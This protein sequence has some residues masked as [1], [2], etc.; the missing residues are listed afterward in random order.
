MEIPGFTIQ[1]RGYFG[2][3]G[4]EGESMTHFSK[5]TYH[6]ALRALT[7]LVVLI[8]AGIPILCA[9]VAASILSPSPVYQTP[10][11]TDNG[12]Y[13]GF[14]P[15]D[16]LDIDPAVEYSTPQYSMLLLSLDPTGQSILLNEINA[17][18]SV[19][20]A[21]KLSMSQAVKAIWQKYPLVTE[22][23]PG[24]R[25]SPTYGG[26]YIHISFDPKLGENVHLT[27]TENSI[28]QQIEAARNNEWKPPHGGLK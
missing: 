1:I 2:S 21:T 3:F 19:D 28:L 7:I 23:R 8:G 6:Q 12:N 20:S 16:L 25:G 15:V 9:P 22:T 11:G 10:P 17:F 5:Q 18:T 13:D 4:K 14:F 26:N 27:T 24:G